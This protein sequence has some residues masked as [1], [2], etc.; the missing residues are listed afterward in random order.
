MGCGSI[1]VFTSQ[2]DEYAFTATTNGTLT[3]LMSD[4]S[5]AKAGTGTYRFHFVKLPGSFII[6]PGD[7]GGPLPGSGG[8]QDGVTGEPGDLDLWTFSATIGDR[9]VLRRAQLTG[10][11]NFGVWMRVYDPNG[12]VINQGAPASGVSMRSRP[13]PTARSRC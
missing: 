6:P 8:I 7:D 3:V 13:R 10:T 12:C 5:G 4:G 11:N 2:V 1:K 9:I